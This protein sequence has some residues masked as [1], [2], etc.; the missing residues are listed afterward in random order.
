MNY[1][2][3]IQMLELKN[4]QYQYK[5][6]MYFD[7]SLKLELGE[8]LAVIGPSGSG[9]TTLLNLISG[10]IKSSEGEIFFNNESILHLPAGM[11]PVNILF[12]ENNNFSHLNV[13]DNVALGISPGLKLKKLQRELIEQA[14]EKVGL[15]GFNLRFPY[16]L[17]GGQKQRV[18]IARTLVRNR[19]ILLLDEAFSSL[20]PPLRVEMLDLVKSL[21]QE[22]SLI[23]IMV[24]HN[25]KEAARI[26]NKTCFIDNGKIIYTNTTKQFAEST[27]NPLIRTYIS[28]I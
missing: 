17:S 8:S 21:Q 12:Q 10:F 27:N 3:K 14:L 7:Y 13:F 19:T 2:E 16:Q 11:R 15:D 5:D 9:K 18:A 25:H 22:H 24:T 4:L 26:C 23:I 6:S 20:D 28:S 1:G